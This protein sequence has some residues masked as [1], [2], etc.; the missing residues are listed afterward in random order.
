MTGV[1]VAPDSSLTPGRGDQTAAHPT[2][3]NSSNWRAKP[4]APQGLMTTHPK[5]GLETRSDPQGPCRFRQGMSQV[6][7]PSA[8]VGVYRTAGRIRHHGGAVTGRDTF[9]LVVRPCWV[10][11]STF[12]VSV[13]GTS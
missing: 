6:R 8:T 9:A 1:M 11:P 7:V 13:G 12:P 10:L 2:R 4:E 3:S 5:H